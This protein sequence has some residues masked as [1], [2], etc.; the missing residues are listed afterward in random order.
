MEKTDKQLKQLSKFLSFVLRHNPAH[1]GITLDEQG[2]VS[3]D[4]LLA[5]MNEHK[6]TLERQ[7][8]ELIVA[9]NNKKRFAFN[10]D[11]SMIRAS[12]GHSIDIDLQL[13]PKEP[14]SFLYHGTTTRFV[15]PI[16]QQGLQKQQ[17]QHVHLSSDFETAKAVGG[18]HGKPVVLTVHAKEMHEAGYQFFLSENNV[19][20]TAEVPI[21]FLK[22][23][24]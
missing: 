5:K 12:Q 6:A 7:T 23:Q 9:T 8:L 11:K 2:W 22:V 18:R 16:M 20:L 4:S 19:W 3:V 24:Q 10:T 17:R 1:I 13:Q 21:K 14:P 15:E